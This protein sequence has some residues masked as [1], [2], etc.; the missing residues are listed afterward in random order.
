M[1]KHTHVRMH[2]HTQHDK[3]LLY[4]PP[5][6]LGRMAGG[7]NTFDNFVRCVASVLILC[8]CVCM[9]LYAYV[10]AAMPFILFHQSD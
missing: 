3:S 6:F 8:V 10:H 2:T 7:I 4:P 9:R 5:P 1:Q